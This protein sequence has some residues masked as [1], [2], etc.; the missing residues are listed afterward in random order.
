MVFKVTL[1]SSYD[2][3]DPVVMRELRRDHMGKE[4]IVT[5]IADTLANDFMHILVYR[6][7]G[8]VN[9]GKEGLYYVAVDMSASPPS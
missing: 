3:T 4:C 2:L 6:F 9:N 5:G 7:G 1:D 8:H